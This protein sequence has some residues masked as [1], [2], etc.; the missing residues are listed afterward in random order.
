[1]WVFGEVGLR[2]LYTFYYF[3]IDASAQKVSSQCEQKKYNIAAQNHKISQTSFE[4]HTGQRKCALVH[5]Y[6][7]KHESFCSTA[8]RIMDLQWAVWIYA[9]SPPPTYS[10]TLRTQRWILPL[11]FP[12]GLPQTCAQ[13]RTVKLVDWNATLLH[14]VKLRHLCD[15]HHSHGKTCDCCNYDL[16]IQTLCWAIAVS[17][18]SGLSWTYKVVPHS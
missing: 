1:M 2:A 11:W 15:H 7:L 14:T 4:V 6:E 12:G 13:H 10:S 9:T 17:T 8:P 18:P 3:F 5:L 16:H